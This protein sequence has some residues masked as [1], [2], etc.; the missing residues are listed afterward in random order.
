MTELLNAYPVIIKQ[1]IAWG[2]LDM[3][4]HVNNV[5]FFRYIENARVAYY[6]KINKY[7][8]ERH[9]GTG[10]V[11]AATECKF[12]SPLTYPAT[13]AVGARVNEISIDHMIMNY[14]LVNLAEDT[15]SAE[16]SAMLVAFDYQKNQKAPFPKVL[17]LRIEDLQK[18]IKI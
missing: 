11:L 2:D 14:R 13:V 7:E 16:A 5:W 3:H 4:G 9:G 10:F 8:Y 15:I 18:D 1:P 12:K 17:K 6:E